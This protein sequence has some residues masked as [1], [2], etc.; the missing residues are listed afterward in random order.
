[1][2]DIDES[3]KTTL[4]QNI[5]NP[6]GRAI[7]KTECALSFHN[8]YSEGG[9]YLDLSSFVSFSPE[10]ALLNYKQTDHPVYLQIQSKKVPK[11]EEE[12]ESK[13]PTVMAIG[14]EGGFRIDGDFNIETEY[15]IVVF[16]DEKHIPYPNENLPD[17]VAENIEFIIHHSSSENDANSAAWVE[18]LNESRFYEN[19]EQVENPPKIPPSGW[20]CAACD[21][22]EN[23]WLNLSTG[24]I[25]CGRRNWDGSGGNGHALAHFEEKN[26]YPL[27]VKLGTITGEGGD[28]FS[29]HPSENDM[30]LNPNLQKH[31]KHFGIDMHKLK[32]TEKTM[33]ELEIDLQTQFSFS[34]LTEN[35]KE[36]TPMYGPGYTGLVNIGNSCYMNSVLQVLFSVPE[37]VETY[38]NV[39]YLHE[40]FGNA[41]NN[42]HTQMAKMCFG[43]HSGKY[44]QPETDNEQQIRPHML[45]SVIANGN[46]DWNSNLQ[47]DAFEYYQWFLQQ[48][49]SNEKNNQ[50]PSNVFKFS[51]EEKLQCTET[52]M[53]KYDSQITNA[54]VLPVNLSNAI[55]LEEYE[56]D[57]A[58]RENGDVPEVQE[59]VIPIVKLLDC[60]QEYSE[61]ETVEDFYSSGAQKKTTAIKQSRFKTFPPYLTFCMRK[62]FVGDD[63]VPKK[64]EVSFEV[65]DRININHLRGTG[66]QSDET[67]LPDPD[68]NEEEEIEI[69]E[70]Y[71][72]AVMNMGF[73]RVQCERA[74]HFT[75]NSGAE[76]AINWLFDHQTDPDINDPL[77]K[78]GGSSSSSG[79]D[80]EAL[81]M[82]QMMG[83]DPVKGAM[84]LAAT[85]GNV[86]AA[87]EWVFSNPDAR[88]EDVSPAGQNENDKEEVL[89]DGEGE[90]ELF[91][92]ISH[93]G[94]SAQVGHYLVHVLKE[95][96]WIKFNDD[97]VAI[98]DDPPID[99][100]YMYFFRRID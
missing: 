52:N 80:P 63:W 20:K 57:K 99:L 33:G 31:L 1:M 95:G 73:P 60:I 29:Y 15:S 28:V 83:I 19:L 65:P 17:Q 36:L 90:Y 5:S 64:M 44:S 59:E 7:H 25:G 8:L 11:E 40:T 72:N 98:S 47:Q 21:L 27:C 69:N 22:K 46:V 13:A 58:A 71:V 51:V 55:N 79:V 66:L 49:E 3:T 76:A 62:F 74:V 12:G 18:Q 53:V 88:P 14:V 70:E 24:Y 38:R 34:K 41:P 97:K 100:A 16:P 84:G 37:F 35:G 50:D 61:P 86:E 26:L 82:L 48:I 92:F 32:K 45:K 56:S 89:V 78:K 93:M 6:Q 42:F 2:M 9:I 43:I 30:V 54:I 96:K 23:L 94:S 75:N 4:L 81:A 77:P 68:N 87:I 91:A 10:N 67:L 39:S 85:N